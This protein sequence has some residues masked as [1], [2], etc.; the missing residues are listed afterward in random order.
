MEVYRGQSYEG[1]GNMAGKYLGASTFIQGQFNKALYVHC[2]NHRLN[3][4]IANTCSLPVVRNMMGTVR[5]LSEF[6]NN[7]PKRQ[8]HS[9]NK[10]ESLLPNSNHNILINV[11]RTR[12]IPRLDGLDGIVELLVPI[13]A[14]LEDI[15]LNRNGEDNA[16]AL[17]NDVDFSFV[18]T[19]VIVRYILD[20]TRQVTVKLQRREMDLLNADQEISSLKQA[21]EDMRINIYDQ[22]HR[23]YEEAVQLAVEVGLD[24]NRPRTVQR[25]IHRS[26]LPSS[27][28]EE[29]YLANL[30]IVF[31]DHSLQ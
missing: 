21:L 20:L 6:F 11:C 9:E 23:L 17:V 10:I 22:H 7:S 28:M 12:Q 24:P 19:L 25:Q 16:Q 14:T 30:T 2:M 13:L 18:V 29:Y 15:G 1:A 26:N 4:C 3:L 8:Q 31:L 5:K 27:S